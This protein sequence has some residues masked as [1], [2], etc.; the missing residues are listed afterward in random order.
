MLSFAKWL[1]AV[2]EDPA[3]NKFVSSAKS[4][5]FTSGTAFDIQNVSLT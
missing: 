2:N 4:L 3:T 1:T 5:S